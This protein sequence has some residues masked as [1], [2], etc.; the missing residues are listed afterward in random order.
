VSEFHVQQFLRENRDCI[1]IYKSSYLRRWWDSLPQ[2]WKEIFQKQ[3]FPNSEPTSEN[4]HHLV[5]MET[6]RIEDIRVQ[7]LSP[8]KAFV[9]PEELVIT[10]T[11]VTDISPVNQLVSLNSLTISE[12]PVDNLDPIRELTLLEE[13]NISKTAVNDLD[14]LS[15]LIHL[16]RLDCSG[17]QI[18]RLDGL[19]HLADLEYLDFSNTRVRRIDPI[20]YL[21]LKDLKCYNTR[22]WTR[23]IDDSRQ[24]NPDCSVTYYK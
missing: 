6:I 22:V 23:S 24:I 20:L 17:T 2:Y 13:L 21:P 10:G 1:V 14:A 7:N 19:T 3:G 16:R 18:K 9:L 8:L 11:N 5:E 12:S 15:D 4:L